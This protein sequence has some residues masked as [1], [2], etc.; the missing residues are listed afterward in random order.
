MLGRLKYKIAS[1]P[2]FNEK[3]KRQGRPDRRQILLQAR[4][5]RRKN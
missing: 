5:S 2:K 4:K 1:T 3:F